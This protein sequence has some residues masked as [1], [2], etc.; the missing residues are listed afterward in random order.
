MYR[1][2]RDPDSAE[3][4]DPCGS[5]ALFSVYCFFKIVFH[6][7]GSTSPAGHKKVWKLPHPGSC[8]TPHP[9]TPPGARSPDICQDEGTG[10][11]RYS[12]LF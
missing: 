10:L 4:K 2:D 7:A 8:D 12:D 1:F 11:L 9:A 6:P 5:K 3:N